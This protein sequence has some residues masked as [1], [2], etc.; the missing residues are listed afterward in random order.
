M[1]TTSVLKHFSKLDKEQIPM[2]MFH[3]SFN[4]F[5]SFQKHILSIS[6]VPGIGDIEM[7]MTDNVLTLVELLL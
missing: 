1:F 5:F 6:Y 4:N 7:N 3:L 2:T